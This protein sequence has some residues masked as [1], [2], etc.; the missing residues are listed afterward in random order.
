L[1]PIR[2]VPGARKTILA[3]V[4]GTMMLVATA[5]GGN[6]SNSGSSGGKNGAGATAQDSAS[7]SPVSKA[8]V[9]VTPKDGADGVET[10]G[11]LKVT[12]A[13]G[14]LTTV[15][16]K[17]SKGNKVDGAIA[18]GGTGWEP[19]G[20]L[21]A[22]TKYT[23]DATAKDSAGGTTTKHTTF[24][25]VTPKA[26]FIGYYTPENGQTVGTGMEVSLNFNHA[27]TDKKAIEKAVK[28]TASPAV[29]V[30][31]HWYGNQRI[32]FRPKNYWAAGTKITLSLHLNGVK[33]ASGTYGTQSKDV[34]F[35]VGRSQVSIVDAAKDTMKV[36][37]SGKL[38]KTV[39]ITSGAPGKTTYNGK[40]VI[41]EKYKTKRMDGATV[42]Y[43]G[44]YDIPDVPHAM[45][46]TTSGTFIHGNYWASSSVFGSSN[47]SHGCVGLRDTKGA[48]DTSTPAYW[49]YTNSIIGDVVQV[50]NSNDKTVAWYNGLNGWNMDWS[51]WIKAS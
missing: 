31:G 48:N 18:G 34:H 20:T 32:D 11:V 13:K 10:S 37:R 9:S 4:I 35:T 50:K 28:V 30:V 22:N 5:C 12:A 3:L 43:Q 45:R 36:Y 46:L 2:T 6:D 26:T 38:I 47:V 42:G 51:D 14:T 24:R 25:T 27:I 8:V 44:Q 19:S 15:V 23:V 33:G 16:V 39:P 29:D 49:F 7:A 1:K 17:D 40:M 41:T 21:A